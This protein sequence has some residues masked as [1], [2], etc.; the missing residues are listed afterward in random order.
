MYVKQIIVLVEKYSLEGYDFT[1]FPPC[2]VNFF[3]FRGYMRYVQVYRPQLDVTVLKHQTSSTYAA[4]I[5][6]KS[7]K[8]AKEID[9]TNANDGILLCHSN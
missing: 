7:E 5:R 4:S 2:F 9:L 6:E 3:H 8:S 1:P